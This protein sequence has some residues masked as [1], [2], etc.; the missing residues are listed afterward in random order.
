MNDPGDV[1]ELGLHDKR[2]LAAHRDGVV[3]QC[4]DGAVVVGPGGERPN[5]G[6]FQNW[7]LSAFRKSS[8]TGSR[9]LRCRERNIGHSLLTV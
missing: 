5:D 7:V 3:E 1:L 9:H 4:S 2:E 8:R 6:H